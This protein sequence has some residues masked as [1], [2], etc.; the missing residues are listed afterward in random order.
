MTYAMARANQTYATMAT[1][2][3]VE[4][5][6]PHR[7]I[8]L[9]MAGA[10]DRIARARGHLQRGEI[11]ARGQSITRAIEIIEGLRVSIDR[12]VQH[13]LTDNLLGLY[14]YMG[15]RLLQANLESSPALLDEVAGLLRE[16]KEGWDA[17]PSV[18]A[19]ERRG[20][21]TPAGV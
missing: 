16:I 10:L 18:I 1:H 3:G 13:P 19:A 2:T 9:L 12:S 7:L 5:A 15:R 11:A 4:G 17:I 8:Q 6:D 20:A 21:G 14:D